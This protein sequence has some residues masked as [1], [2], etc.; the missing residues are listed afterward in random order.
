MYFGMELLS[1]ASNTIFFTFYTFQYTLKTQKKLFY[2]CG[3]TAILR[4]EILNRLHLT[5]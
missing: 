5:Q 2:V 1:V 4:L 3:V